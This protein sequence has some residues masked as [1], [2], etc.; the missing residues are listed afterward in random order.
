[1]R[2]RTLS[3]SAGSSPP[4]RFK[5]W[6]A[7]NSHHVVRRSCGGVADIGCATGSAP[8]L[9]ASNTNSFIIDEAE[10]TYWCICPA[11]QLNTKQS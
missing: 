11:R 4:A 7:D 6:V 3:S 10:V 5:A 9:E 2:C 1:V 8:C